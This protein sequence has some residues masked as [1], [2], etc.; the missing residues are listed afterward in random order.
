MSADGELEEVLA[1]EAESANEEAWTAAEADAGERLDM[2]VV[3]RLPEL[4]RSR[5][6]ALI[7]AGDI[8]LNAKLA[9]AGQKLRLGD[10]IT[11][12][13][14]PPQPLDVRPEP[15]PLAVVYEDSDLLVIDKPKGMVVHPAPG[16]ASGT[17]VNA[18]LHHCQDLSGIGGAIR[19]GIVHRLDKD[20]S[21]LL[22]VAK[23]D[24]AH[25]GL[26]AQI[27]SK[28][29]KRHYRAVV[30]GNLAEDAGQVEAPIARHPVDRQRMAVVATGKPALTYWK[31]LERFHGFTDLALE[32]ATGRT[33]QIR[34]HMAHL[35][36]PVVGDPVYGGMVKL[37][38]ALHGQA[39]HAAELVLRHPRT[40]ERMT[41]TAPLPEEY[42]K[43]LRYLRQTRR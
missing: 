18:L 26:A 40:G 27:A 13:I 12:E 35:R 39:L 10:A 14:P 16:H 42:E 36:H 17:L 41:F 5:V 24:L 19:P 21:G 22:V 38:V 31:V 34:V 33:H 15:I 6:Q 11:V 43:L 4:S 7:E 20:T 29:A 28:E 25:H 37:P 9:K 1:A 3:A 32:L 23:N 30:I 2:A 8:R